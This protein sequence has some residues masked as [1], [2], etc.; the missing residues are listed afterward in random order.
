[1]RHI[2]GRE[3]LRGDDPN[4]YSQKPCDNETLDHLLSI[5][6]IQM[7]MN[8]CMNRCKDFF[9]ELALTTALQK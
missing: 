4:P 6:E 7:S 1:M 2:S 5:V 3:L 9:K 8:F